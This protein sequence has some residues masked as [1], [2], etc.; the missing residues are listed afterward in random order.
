MN[1]QAKKDPSI[2]LRRAEDVT[3]CMHE[4]EDKGFKPISITIHENHALI[5]ISYTPKTKELKGTSCGITYLKGFL[6][7]VYQVMLHNVIV[8]WMEPQF[9]ARSGRV[10]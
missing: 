10:H 4:L 2:L 9:H 3:F 5:C 1:T 8:K 6:H 7:E